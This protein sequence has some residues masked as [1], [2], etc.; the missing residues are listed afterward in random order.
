MA[1]HR[2]IKA[3]NRSRT[4]VEANRLRTPESKTDTKASRIKLK[5]TENMQMI[6]SLLENG[7]TEL[8]LKAINEQC[9]H[10]QVASTDHLEDE[11]DLNMDSQSVDEGPDEENLPS[12]QSGSNIAID[13][14]PEP[15]RGF[16]GTPTQNREP[17]S[18]SPTQLLNFTRGTG[19]NECTVKLLKDSK[20]AKKG[21]MSEFLDDLYK[22]D[23]EERAKTRGLLA[24]FLDDVDEACDKARR[25]SENQNHG[26]VAK[27]ASEVKA[28]LKSTLVVNLGTNRTEA[29]ISPKPLNLE[30]KTNQASNGAETA[31]KGTRSMKTGK[32]NSP[33]T[34]NQAATPKKTFAEV[35]REPGKGQTGQV[36]LP[37]RVT[38]PQSNRRMFVRLPKDSP[39]RKQHPLFN[40]QKVNR[41]LSGDKGLETTYEVQSG[42]ALL[43]NTQTTPKDLIDQRAR[44]EESFGGPLE[45]DTRW[46][47]A[48]VHGIP[49]RLNYVN[50]DLV[51]TTREPDMDQEV[52]PAIKAAF[53]TTPESALLR[54]VLQD[55]SSTTLRL[56]FQPDKMTATPGTIN[57]L[58]MMASVSYQTRRPRN[59]APC[60][61]CWKTGHKAK[62]CGNNDNPSTDS[63]NNRTTPAT[64]EGAHTAP[65]ELASSN[66]QSPDVRDEPTA[67]GMEDEQPPNPS[68]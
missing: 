20:W 22:R 45:S 26:T 31:P 15:N 39:I 54:D 25:C 18:H 41:I 21:E 67:S 3:Q 33:P 43:L 14:E 68:W 48:K 53:G 5:E 34:S 52:L 37:K 66:T 46:M 50:D 9:D 64:S 7:N 60:R 57:V 44:I 38:A 30:T 13:E 1:P 10:Q 6:K 42:I 40:V 16:N 58:G 2:T 12:G 49:R 61:S 35:A 29:S 62:D 59:T 63:L 32:N 47:I 8:A 27:I 19:E 56:A 65:K 36:T 23:E 28:F 24:S 4:S 55:S 11:T 51:L 17:E